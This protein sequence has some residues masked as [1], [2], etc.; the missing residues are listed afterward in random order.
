MLAFI[1]VDRSRVTI[2]Q[3]GSLAALQEPTRITLIALPS[4]EPFGVIHTVGDAAATDVGWIGSPPRLLVLSRLETTTRVRIVDPRAARLVAERSLDVLAQL[5]AC[6]DDH[7]LVSGGAQTL[8]V[9]CRGDELVVRPVRMRAM[10]ALAGAM[11]TR[12]VMV[13]GGGLRE[14]DPRSVATKRSWRISS[15]ATVTALGGT[16]RVLWRTTRET[17]NRIDVIPLIALGQPKVH[18]LP[19]PIAQ[20]VGHPRRDVLACLGAESGRVF[21]VDLEGTYPLRAID[22]GPIDHADA[23]GLVGGI[24]LSVLVSQHTR[25]TIVVPLGMPTWRNELVAWTRSGIVDRIP[26]VPAIAQL[27]KHLDLPEALTPALTLCYGAHLCGATGVPPDDLADVL[28]GHWPEEVRGAG[29]L[30][31]TRVLEFADH[32]IAMASA[33]RQVLDE[34]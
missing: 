21:V 16:D 29:R 3:D 10:P 14:W 31:A 25:P 2:A 22:T 18:E 4:G 20:A 34:L 24:D 30:A 17:P 8:T 26:L 13:A 33:Y 27:A 15:R 5:R 11:H 23:I 6:V 28:G 1:P 9:T 7:A 19:E 12:F 32:G